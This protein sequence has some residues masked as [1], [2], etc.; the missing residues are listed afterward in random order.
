[1]TAAI[2][3]AAASA[4]TIVYQGD[5]GSLA[6]V[7]RRGLVL[8]L[9]GLGVVHRHGRDCPQAVRVAR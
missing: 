7:L 6:T 8:R 4:G 2:V 1:M 3:P 5:T 9:A